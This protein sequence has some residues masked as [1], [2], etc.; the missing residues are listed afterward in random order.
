MKTTGL[1]LSYSE[2]VK[3]QIHFHSETV[4]KKTKSEEKR[5][6]TFC[7]KPQNMRKFI[8]F[9]QENCK[10]SF[11]IEK[12][13]SHDFAQP[14]QSKLSLKVIDPKLCALAWFLFLSCP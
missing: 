10:S 12:K 5:D 7:W 2:C 8:K 14:V 1:G 13:H 3:S 6:K 4:E 9:E 11:A